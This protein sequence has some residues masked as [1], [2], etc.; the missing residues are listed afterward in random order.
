MSF[1]IV[2]Q[3]LGSP[4]SPTPDSLKPYLSEFLMDPLVID[5]PWVLRTLLVK[6]IIVPTRSKKSAHAYKKIWTEAGSPLVENTRVFCESLQK[7][8]G[9]PVLMTMRYGSLNPKYTLQAWVQKNNVSKI[10]FLSMYPQYALSSSRSSIDDF[11]SAVKSLNQNIQVYSVKDFFSSKG[12]I[13]AL[14]DSVKSFTLQ[15]PA[16]HIL[17]SYHGV[18]KRHLKKAVP[19]NANCTI[20]ANC[21][22]V[23]TDENQD[24]YRAACMATTRAVVAKLSLAEGSYTTAFQSRLGSGWIEPFTDIVIPKLAKQGIKRIA[25]VTPSFTTDCLETLEEIGMRAKEDFLSAGGEELNLI[26][27]LNSSP[28]WVEVVAKWMSETATEREAEL[29]WSSL[30]NL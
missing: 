1:G 25:V 22:D 5:I 18:P 3:N 17:F 15:N 19:L 21:C 7:T 10:L 6:G 26:P 11:K 4:A 16:D 27:C 23:L 20:A 9:L 13:D 24:C 2:I 30:E 29:K 8:S 28:Q 12:Y 14:A